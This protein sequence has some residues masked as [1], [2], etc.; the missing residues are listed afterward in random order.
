[1]FY[2]CKQ[3]VASVAAKPVAAPINEPSVRQT[4]RRVFFS[5]TYSRKCVSCDQKPPVKD[6]IVTTTTDTARPGSQSVSG[7]K[8]IRTEI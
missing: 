5:S 2:H 6:P 7:V 4:Q 3:I 1:M 8:C